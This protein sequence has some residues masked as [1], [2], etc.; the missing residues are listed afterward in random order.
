M[1]KLKKKEKQ[2]SSAA[3]KSMS[4]SHIVM[5]FMTKE[6]LPSKQSLKLI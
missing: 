2:E 1:I 3:C 4:F 6:Q 5:M